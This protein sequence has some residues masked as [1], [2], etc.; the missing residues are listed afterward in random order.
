MQYRYT[1][2]VSIRY[3]AVDYSD[4]ERFPPYLSMVSKEYRSATT[5]CILVKSK[6]YSYFVHIFIVLFS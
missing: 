1:P 2:S 5:L 3:P 4:S 6:T